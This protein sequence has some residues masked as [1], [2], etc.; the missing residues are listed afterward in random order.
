MKK[1]ILLATLLVTLFAGFSSATTFYEYNF[2]T[3][4]EGWSA[5]GGISAGWIDMSAW[6][7]SNLMHISTCELDD[8][9]DEPCSDCATFY[10]ED[11]YLDSNTDTL[12][13]YS[14]GSDPIYSPTTDYDGALVVKI[15]DESGDWSRVYEDCAAIDAYDLTESTIDLSDYAGQTVTIRFENFGADCGSGETCNNERRYVDDITIIGE[16]E[17]DCSEI[18][19][20]LDD[21]ESS[22]SSLEEDVSDH[23]TRITDLEDTVNDYILPKLKILWRRVMLISKPLSA[24]EL[25]PSFF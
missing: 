22:V 17:C 23:E 12:S 14:S 15:M 25:A 11:L 21:L 13:F 20:R 7:M 8:D 16:S 24:G 1:L 5:E 10:M 3:D 9:S 19:E 6:S 4:A 18:E 2:D